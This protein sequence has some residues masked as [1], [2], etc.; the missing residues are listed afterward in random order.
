[1]RMRK[2]VLKIVTAVVSVLCLAVIMIVPALAGTTQWIYPSGIDYNSLQQVPGMTGPNGEA[3]FLEP[4]TGNYY[5]FVYTQPAYTQPAA[6]SCPVYSG[7]SSPIVIDNSDCSSSKGNK[8]FEKAN[9][10]T[11]ELKD[12]AKDKDWS[13]TV[14]NQTESDTL[15]QR[16]F[17]FV[18]ESGRRYLDIFME[19]KK[20]DG[21]YKTKYWC[22]NSEVDYNDIKSTLKKYKDK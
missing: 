21:D 19:V 5:Y 1:M 15:V 14:Y 9:K 12:Y 3:V 22:G 7:P 13:V 20:K 8:L 6:S 10:K 4:A 17:H 18:N 16:S 2:L 11:N